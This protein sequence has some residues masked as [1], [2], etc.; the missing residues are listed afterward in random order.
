LKN[1]HKIQNLSVEEL[2]RFYQESGNSDYFGELYKR[3]I[4]KIYGLCLKYLS[5]VES[6]RDAVMDIY[7]LLN[8]KIRHYQIENLNAW[9]YSVTKNHCLQI[10]RK[11]KQAILVKIE[12]TYVENTDIFAHTDKPQ[13]AEEIAALEYCMKTLSEEQQKSISLFYF[14]EKSYSDIVE[15]TGYALS[16]VKS[17]IQNG[18]RNLKSC[19]LKVLK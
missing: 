5:D 18:K 15:L 13:S 11:E 4:P 9:L 3:Y 16:K 2:F 6:A 10:L 7:E 19:I 14:E 17:Y 1:R 12:D 8:E